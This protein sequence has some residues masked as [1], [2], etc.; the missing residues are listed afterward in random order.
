M[1]RTRD[2]ITLVCYLFAMTTLAWAQTRKPGLWTLTS[3]TTWQQSPVPPGVGGSPVGG[4]S[5][6][7]GGTNTT[8]VC[9]TQQQIDKYGAIL[10]PISGC[11]L[12]NL[13]KNTNRMTAEMVCTGSMSGKASLESSWTDDVHATGKTHF[14]GSMQIGP[15]TKPIEWTT[16]S[17]SIY[18][19]SDCGS[20][21][22]YPP[23]PDK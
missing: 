22:P 20:V 11:R 1:R 6:F 14:I 12:T 7:D 23:L 21:K 13:V 2:G 3:T 10:P 4:N 5:P 17:T 9:L 18:K 8:Q 19:G 15:N 16:A